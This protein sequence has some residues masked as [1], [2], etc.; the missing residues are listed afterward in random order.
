[1]TLFPLVIGLALIQSLFGVG[2]LVMGTPILLLLDTPYVDALWTLLPCSVTVSALQLAVDRGVSRDEVRQTF[3][4]AVPTLV[5]GML[6]AQVYG[7]PL[8]FEVLIAAMLVFAAILR[9]SSVA[10]TRVRGFATRHQ[11]TLLGGIGV[12]HGMTN[13]GGTLLLQLAAAR[14]K[15]KLGVRQ[16]TALGYVIMAGMQLITL[17]ATSGNGFRPQTLGLAACAGA[18]F[19]VVGRRSFAHLGHRAYNTLLASFMLVIAAVLVLKK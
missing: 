1:M 3:V 9:V 5:V 2:L 15:D 8:R 7:T 14:R 18:T 11:S 17:L 4:I 10:A 6:A 16:Y 13:M 19:L 12:I